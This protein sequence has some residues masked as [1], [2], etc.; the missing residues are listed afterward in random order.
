MKLSLEID[1]VSVIVYGLE[2]RILRLVY[3]TNLY[4]KSISKHI[5]V[6]I[7]WEYEECFSDLKN[8]SL[9]KFNKITPISP[10]MRKTQNMSE[11]TSSVLLAHTVLKLLLL[12]VVL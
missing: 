4:G 3:F 1:A 9:G 8:S 6:I 12:L 7:S 10:M 5:V 2:F 11:N